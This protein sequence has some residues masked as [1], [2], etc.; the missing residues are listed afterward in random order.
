[1]AQQTFYVAR[2]NFL[3]GLHLALDRDNNYDESDDRLRSD[4]LLSALYACALELGLAE[5]NDPSFMERYRLSSAFP[6]W[7]GEGGVPPVYFFPRPLDPQLA[8]DFED[9][10]TENRKKKGGIE[11]FDLPLFEDVIAGRKISL[12][13]DNL[14]KNNRLASSQYITSLQILDNTPFQHVA[15]HDWEDKEPVPYYVDKLFFEE[16]CGLYFLIECAEDHVGD[17]QACLRLLADNGIGT[18]RSSG[19]GAFDWTEEDWGTL[20]L[21]VPDQADG[22]WMSLSLFIPETPADLGD[23]EQ[24][25]Y[26]L[27]KRGGYIASSVAQDYTLMTIR[28]KSIMAFE[29]GSLLHTSVIPS[30]RI[31]DL[32]PDKTALDE[33][34]KKAMH[35][36]WRSGRAIF[37]PTNLKL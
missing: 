28:K 7:Q 27:T 10:K 15:I 19:N 16:G 36:I 25:A 22:R 26:E 1:M 35:P 6:F 5:S 23:L 14:S 21:N 2:L 30:G 32:Q 9:N 13:D 31:A 8:I 4:T 29:E 18:D 24:A 17:L 37:I 3:S 12:K 34:K 11:Y 33:E 20:Q